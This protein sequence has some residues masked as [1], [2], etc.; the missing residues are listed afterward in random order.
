MR[1]HC[2]KKV[3]SFIPQGPDFI[4]S[5]SF[6]SCGLKLVTEEYRFVQVWDVKERKLLAQVERFSRECCYFSSCSKY[7]VAVQNEK[8][9]LWNLTKLKDID[10]INICFDTCLKY[11]DN[12]QILAHPFHDDHRF[13]DNFKPWHFHLPNDQIVVV[14][15]NKTPEKFFVW[16]NRKCVISVR[17]SA[18][19]IWDIKNQEVIDRFHVDCLPP[20]SDID[21][22][23]KLDETNFLFCFNSRHVVVLSLKTFGETSVNSCVNSFLK[24][25]TVSPDHL[26]VA[27]CYE[28]CVLTITNV[29]NGETL[30][31]VELQKAPEACWWSELYLWVVCKDAVLK[32]PYHSADE[33][34]LEGDSEEFAINF[35]RVLK[36]DH[37]VLVSAVDNE[38]KRKI[39]ASKICDD[40]VPYPSEDENFL[41]SDPD[42]LSECIGCILEIDNEII[43]NTANNIHGGKICISKICDGKLCSQPLGNLTLGFSCVAI[44]SD[45]CAVLLLR[46]SEYQLWE[47]ARESG[48]ELYS[49]E[50]LC[51]LPYRE[52]LWF[53][54]TGTRNVRTL[55]WVTTYCDPSYT[56]YTFN[57]LKGAHSRYLPNILYP[58]YVRKVCYVAPN[59][60]L[61]FSGKFIHV[62]NPSDGEIITILY[63]RE[64]SEIFLDASILYLSSKRLLTFVLPNYIKCFK[65]HNLENLLAL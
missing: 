21:R 8:L 57:S 9:F 53:S 24:C 28:N 26:Y 60:V 49:A 65:I 36:F 43:V 45:G 31:T 62:F 37:G 61:L 2:K 51:S 41:E 27:C 30:Q 58:N 14:V 59:V 40:K 10:T 7:I 29:V 46:R 55:E 19:E 32:F 47:F 4:F 23:S 33:E 34:V 38:N 56:R 15:P 44:S 39:R 25:V 5:C 11:K 50:N 16:K 35:N 52:V 48:W 12:F 1:V 3:V 17:P 6:S 64:D 18:L 63:F 22:I 20:I 13:T 42:E 54:L